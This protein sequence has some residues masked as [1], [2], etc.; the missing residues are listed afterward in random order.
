MRRP[1]IDSAEEVVQYLAAHPPSAASFHLAI[2]DD[3]T[4]AGQPDVM[5]A[6]MAVVLDK[7][8]ALGYMPDGFEQKKGYRL[9]RYKKG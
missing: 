2:S 5:G 1:I 8:L 4:F 6:G 7:L 3:F 9:Y